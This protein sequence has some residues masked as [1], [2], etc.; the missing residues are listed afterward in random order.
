MTNYNNLQAIAFRT[1]EGDSQAGKARIE[2]Y[3]LAAFESKGATKAQNV[4]LVAAIDGSDWHASGD[5]YLNAVRF[6]TRLLSAFDGTVEG[7]MS[8]LQAWN[9]ENV[10]NDGKVSW[11]LE[12]V[13][14]KV[15][16][17]K[18][19]VAPTTVLDVD[20]VAASLAAKYGAN[21]HAIALAML[22]V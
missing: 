16:P 10:A 4:K 21:T 17:T 12:G 2:R 20:K 3:V 19:S 11:S 15:A 5:A 9:D 6:G 13:T 1:I 22:A 18:A 7:T 14:N 8:S